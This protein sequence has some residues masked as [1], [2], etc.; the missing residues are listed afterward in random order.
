[1]EAQRLM[2]GARRAKPEIKYNGRDISDFVVDFSYTDNSDKTDDISVKLD[3]RDELWIGD[4][5]PET[6]DTVDVS[7]RV[8]DWNSVGDNRMLPYGLFEVDN[9][10]YDDAM[11]INAVAVP[12]TASGRSEKKT[13]AWKE[14]ALSSIAS[15]IAGTAGL[16]L[17]Y[18]TAIDPY[19]DQ[20]DQNDK[21]DLDFLTELCKSDGLCVKE[22]DGQLIVFEESAYDA[23]PA[24][25]TIR[26][27]STDIYGNPKFKRN[28]KNIYKACEISYFDS[29]T[30]TT[31]TG[32]F[33]APSVG[34]VG[35]TLKLRENF[36]SEQDDINLDRKA[37]ARLR[38]QNKKEWTCDIKLKGDITYCAGINIQLVGWRR[39][40][41]KY[42]VETCTHTIGSGGYVVSLSTRRCL[43][44]Y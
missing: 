6:G 35:H 21:S 43:E 20:T 37:K 30:D 2:A 17:T 10:N 39:F 3:D 12:I 41:G 4:W 16:S 26:R 23:A 19:Y 33:S 31:Y 38:E 40:D 36:N 18:D 1:M 24:M 29:K 13:K 7:I 34:D 15:D 11:S 25:I 44:G 32:S 22:T 5:F 9:T 14:I 42:H 28:A 8:Y 27:G